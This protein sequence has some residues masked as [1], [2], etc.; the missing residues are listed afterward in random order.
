MTYLG[1]GFN[2]FKC[3]YVHS[4]LNTWGLWQTSTA[5]VIYLDISSPISCCY[6]QDSKHFKN[7]IIIWLSSHHALSYFHAIWKNEFKS[8][9]SWMYIS[10]FSWTYAVQ[11][12]WKMPDQFPY[13]LSKAVVCFSLVGKTISLYLIVLKCVICMKSYFKWF[14]MCQT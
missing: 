2:K 13:D 9:M 4:I 3:R 8:D 10:M 1:W 12:K 7:T 6:E 5:L 11:K 14:F